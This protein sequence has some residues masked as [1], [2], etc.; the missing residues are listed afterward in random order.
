M[1]TFLLII[2]MLLLENC[3][4]QTIFKGLKYNMTES[5]AKK[6]FRANKDQYDNVDFGNG[7]VWRLYQQNFLYVD[8]KLVGVL[9][10][11]KGGGFG[12]SHNNV[13]NYLE[14][15]RSF[16][17]NKG[18]TVI[19]EP[20]AWQYPT[21]FNSKYGLLLQNE[22][23]T[24]IVQL[25]PSTYTVNYSTGYIAYMKVI[26]YEFFMKAYEMGNQILKEKSENSGF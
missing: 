11:P 23:K 25:N 1:K 19:F 14:F 8:D 15:S 24:I 4:T 22:D 13:I 26:N 21:L 20:E 6:E 5:E 3:F 17:E 9:F 2:S 7:F 10:S 12:Q 16:F 18:Y